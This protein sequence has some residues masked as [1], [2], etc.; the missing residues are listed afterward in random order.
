MLSDTFALVFF[1][2]YFSHIIIICERP[3]RKLQRSFFIFH[4][5]LKIEGK[6]TKRMKVDRTYNLSSMENLFWGWGK[7]SSQEYIFSDFQLCSFSC[8]SFSPI[9]L[10]SFDWRGRKIFSHDPIY[11]STQL[12]L[13]HISSIKS[14]W[15]VI[16]QRVW[17]VFFC[18][19][20][21]MRN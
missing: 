19:Q 4:V 2:I 9:R 17:L 3:Q 14:I 18:W 15:T 12:W 5:C 1:C 6:M 7:K 11:S 8:P 16:Q 21:E 20:W 13:S 10:I